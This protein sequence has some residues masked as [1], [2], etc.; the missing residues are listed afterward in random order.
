MTKA[1]TLVS[2]VARALMVG[3]SLSPS[4]LTGSGFGIGHGSKGF[5]NPFA[6]SFLNT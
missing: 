3:T 5:G 4:N 2:A 1:K 6:F